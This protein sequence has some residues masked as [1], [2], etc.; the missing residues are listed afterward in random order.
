MGILSVLT[1]STFSIQADG[2]SS[3]LMQV[4]ETVRDNVWGIPLIVL[5]MGAGLLLTVRTGGL[6]FRRLGKALKYMWFN[7]EGGEGEVSSFGALCT[8]L[9]ATIG[10]GNIV[11]VATAVMAGGPGALFWMLVAAAVGMATKY[12]EGILAVKYRQL[13]AARKRGLP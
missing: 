6:Q 7:E 3:T 12:S 11:G 1:S 2:E 9:A 4:V 8:A 5:I 13:R 10:T